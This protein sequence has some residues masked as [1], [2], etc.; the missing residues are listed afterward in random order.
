LQNIFANPVQNTLDG[1][2][3]RFDSALVILKGVNVSKSKNLFLPFIL[4]VPNIRDKKGIKKRLWRVVLYSIY[5]ICDK[6]ILLFSKGCRLSP[7]L[8]STRKKADKGKCHE[9]DIFYVKTF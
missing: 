6:N 2:A 9:M 8:Y 7:L 4:V 5:G 3:K 1:F